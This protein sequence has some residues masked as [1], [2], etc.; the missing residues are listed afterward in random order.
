MDSDDEYYFDDS[1]DYEEVYLTEKD[2]EDFSVA[3]NS[4]QNEN[5]IELSHQDILKRM[6][7]EIE[8]V[9]SVYSDVTST[10]A[11]FLLPSCKWQAGEVIAAL[12]DGKEKTFEKAGIR[13]HNTLN[14]VEEVRQSGS[15]VK[16]ETCW[17]KISLKDAADL[18][19]RHVFCVDCLGK[20][21]IAHV[22][23]RIAKIYCPGI[24]CNYLISSDYIFK[25]LKNEKSRSCYIYLLTQIYIDSNPEV[26][27]CPEPDCN[28]VIKS[29]TPN[30]DYNVKCSNGHKSCFKCQQ[31]WHDPLDCVNL[32]KWL[33]TRRQVGP[34]ANWILENTKDCPK[35][36]VTIQ[37][38]G[39]ENHI[40]CIWCDASWCWICTVMLHEHAG[41]CS[42][43]TKQFSCYKA[44]EKREELE[45]YNFYFIW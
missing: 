19:C 40:T 24:N 27:L 23:E 4:K 13:I 25:M 41:E 26:V 9:T 42:Q 45:R 10:E 11:R 39:I 3:E 7:E 33:E 37:K 18:K 35:C 15:E 20:S 28:V 1:S 44:L 31:P 5:Y 8:N 14:K 29:I 22:N 36:G 16:C 12:L 2:M 30:M 17:N 6:E 21:I 34:T 38:D 43:I 32:K